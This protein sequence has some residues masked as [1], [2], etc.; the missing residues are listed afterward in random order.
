V[1]DNPLFIHGDLKVSSNGRYLIHSDG[2][3]FLWIGETGWRSIQ[4]SSISEWEQYI[5]TRSSQKFSVVQ[6]S[7]KGTS[8]IPGVELA[9]ISFKQDW[10]P[11]PEFW[12]DLE[13]KIRYANSQGLVVFMVG[14]SKT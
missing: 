13:I 4:K 3:P 6:V 14:I 2:T 10:I 1:G 11:D 12:E 8:K 5:D 7:P 9:A